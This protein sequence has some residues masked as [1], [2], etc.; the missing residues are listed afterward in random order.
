MISSSI[1]LPFINS[2][3][4]EHQYWAVMKFGLQAIMLLFWNFPF[5][6]TPFSHFSRFLWKRGSPSHFFLTPSQPLFPTTVISH[7]YIHFCC[8]PHIITDPQTFRMF[9]RHPTLAS[10]HLGHK[11][12]L[13]SAPVGTM[14][15]GDSREHVFDLISPQF[16][17][18]VT[19]F[20]D[21]SN[22]NLQICIFLWV[23][24]MWV[25]LFLLSVN[26]FFD[27]LVTTGS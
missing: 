22:F 4:N 18:E 3:F 15:V 11:V 25:N 13:N 2:A 14:L 27:H 21:I 20:L 9:L 17:V 7:H 5:V 16:P 8:F 26:L 24:F 1:F 19:I 6:E 12:S 10:S 23:Q